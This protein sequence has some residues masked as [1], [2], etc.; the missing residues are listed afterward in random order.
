MGVQS[1]I[2]WLIAI[3]KINTNSFW[4]F[5][6]PAILFRGLQIIIDEL[7]RNKLMNLKVEALRLKYEAQ[8]LEALA[9]LEVYMKNSGRYW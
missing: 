6:I 1:N 2:F 5:A 4:T 7:K 8:K 3:L 9:T